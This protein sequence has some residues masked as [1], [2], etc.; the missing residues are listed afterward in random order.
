MSFGLLGRAGAAQSGYCSAMQAIN[1]YEN[2]Y[3][4]LQRYASEQRETATRLAELQLR[5]ANYKREIRRKQFDLE[6]LGDKN[7]IDVEFK[8][9]SPTKKI[10]VPVHRFAKV[11]RYT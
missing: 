4:R 1:G 3:D 11:T 6:N 2:Y 7:V 5:E 9:V 10:G 8:E